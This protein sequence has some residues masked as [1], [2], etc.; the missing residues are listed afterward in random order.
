[1]DV[2]ITSHYR[3][4][5]LKKIRIIGDRRDLES[6]FTAYLTHLS[7]MLREKTPEETR[8]LPA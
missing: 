8:E 3:S 5:T 6:F 7:M 4:L 1:M 2:L